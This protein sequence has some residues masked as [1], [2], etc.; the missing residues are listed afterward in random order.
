MGGNNVFVQR[1]RAGN[2][3]GQLDVELSKPRGGGGHPIKLNVKSLGPGRF[4]CGHYDIDLERSNLNRI[5]WVDHRNL[6]KSSIWIRMGRGGVPGGSSLSDTGQP[7]V[8]PA[9]GLLR[10]GT[11]KDP[12]SDSI[13]GSTGHGAGA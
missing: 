2:R 13:G 12:T 9:S 5:V 8:P 10:S 7:W 3:G 4:S 6:G 1:A 11:D